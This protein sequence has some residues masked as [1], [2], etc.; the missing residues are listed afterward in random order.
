MKE[1]FMESGLEIEVMKGT[2]VGFEGVYIS[3]YFYHLYLFAIIHQC[4]NQ[5]K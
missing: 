4:H 3:S 2:V 5:P 1:K